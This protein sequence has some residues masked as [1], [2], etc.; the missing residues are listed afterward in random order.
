MPALCMRSLCDH[1]CSEVGKFAA[2]VI[3][4]MLLIAIITISFVADTAAIA[5]VDIDVNVDVVISKCQ[6]KK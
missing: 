1:C 5:A 3:A 2:I 4:L 6:S